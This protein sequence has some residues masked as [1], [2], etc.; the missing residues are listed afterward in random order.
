MKL[1]RLCGVIAVLLLGACVSAPQSAGLFN[2]FR[3]SNN[4]SLLAPVLLSQVPFFAQD[5]YQCGPAALATVLQVSSIS[6]TP[7]QLVPLVY[8]PGRQ[9]SFQVEMLAATRSHG[10]IAYRLT[11]TLKALFGEVATGRPVLVLQ[12][13][14]LAWYPHWHFAVVKGF[15]VQAGQVTLNSG[16]IENYIMQ[17]KTFERTWARAQHWATLTLVPG[18]L[19]VIA[20]APSY[21][22]A[23]AAFE[24]NNPPALAVAAYLSGLQRWPL[25]INLR[26][27]YGNL[28]YEQQLPSEALQQFTA[29][30]DQHP[31]YA[32]AHNNMAQILLE[33]GQTEAA[34]RHAQTA[35]SLGGEYLASYL[36]TLQTALQSI[37][38]GKLPF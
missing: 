1:D 14:G 11:P 25:D 8:V 34:L 35:V 6:V 29:V 20:E 7:A 22:S 17:I 32:P 12:N 27:G 26:M 19:P 9:G 31:D 30:L 2:E 16:L 28:L 10:R 37:N 3:Q 5:L 15:D 18:E 33:Q 24:H 36:S 4:A 38:A 23:L 21:F 13:L